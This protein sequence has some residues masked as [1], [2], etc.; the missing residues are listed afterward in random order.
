MTSFEALGP[1]VP[2]ATRPQDILVIEPIYI[3]FLESCLSQVEFCSR[4]SQLR[5]SPRG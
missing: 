3:H 4:H 5:Y 2:E 1:G